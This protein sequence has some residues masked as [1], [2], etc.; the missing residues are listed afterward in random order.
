MS[1][2]EY[3]LG[4]LA[5]ISGLSISEMVGGLHRLLAH[6]KRV[7]WHWLTPLTALY[8][9]YLIL[10]SWWVS[11]LSF[12]GRTDAVALWQFLLPVAQLICLFIAARGVLP[13]EMP[14]EG[15]APLELEKFYYSTKRYVWGALAS[16][17][18]L[19]I[20]AYALAAAQGHT[21]S[22]RMG[23]TFP[24]MFFG[25]AYYAALAWFDS[26]WVH[27]IAVPLAL[28]IITALTAGTVIT[29]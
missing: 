15:Q 27:R 18:V 12:H 24:V 25:L 1:L 5:I 23:L 2:D 22:G 13:D 11:W 9:A 26:P 4:L 3:I 14:A 17:S 7:N 6:R 28:V 16:N 8:I 19:L 20:V 21:S 10:S 29:G